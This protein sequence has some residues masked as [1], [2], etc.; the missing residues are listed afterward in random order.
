MVLMN[1]DFYLE[2][3]LSL[4]S[5]DLHTRFKDS[6]F[7]L[8]R[9][10]E[11]YKLLFPT[12][13]DHSIFHAINVVN[14]GNK[15][16]NEYADNLNADELYCFLMA[17]YLHDIGMGLNKKDYN[18]F[19]SY[20]HLP[21]VQEDEVAEQIRKNHNDFSGEFIKKYSEFFDF[22]SKEHE[23][24]IIQIA[25]GHRKTDLY[26][27]EEYPSALKVP[28]GNT[29]C[30][31]YLASIIR[32][33]DEVDVA[34]DRNITDDLMMGETIE[35]QVAFGTHKAIKHLEV[36]PDCFVMDVDVSDKAIYKYV[37]EQNEKVKET[38]RYCVDVVAKRTPYRIHQDKIVV[39]QV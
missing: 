6:I 9:I 8:N 16:I 5:S 3:R 31:P 30:L 37:I 14:F 11:S 21:E 10:L 29:I 34:S 15:I 2:K 20:L 19:R 1:N 7:A 17:C 4:L 36:C 18:N 12:Y 33:A 13:T 39:H 23:F 38:I 32:L 26:N 35:S 22:P 28:C 24:A 25:R 27:C